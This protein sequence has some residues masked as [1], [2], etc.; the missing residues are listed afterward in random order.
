VFGQAVIAA[1][2]FGNSKCNTLASR[3]RQRA[4]AE[5]AGKIE[6]SLERSGTVGDE[7][8]QIWRFAE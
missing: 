7:A 5:R 4:F 3:R 8:K 2:D 1:I 6:I